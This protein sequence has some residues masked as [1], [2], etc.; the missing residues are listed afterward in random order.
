MS[1]QSFTLQ[2]S[3]SPQAPLSTFPSVGWSIVLLLLG[4]AV[5]W[6]LARRRATQDPVAKN[7]TG[8]LDGEQPNFTQVLQWVGHAK[9]FEK[10][11][12]YDE[13]VSIYD[14]GLTQHPQ[15]FRL[16]HERGL[17]LARLGRFEEAISSYDRAYELKPTQRDLAHERGDALLKLERYEEAIASFN[18]YL[19]Y[20]PNSGH[21]LSDKG[22]VLYQLNRYEEAL[23]ALNK[24]LNA[25]DGDR[26]AKAYAHSYQIAALQKLGQLEAA[27]KSCQTAL[28]R[29]PQ[30]SFKQQYEMLQQ[31]IA[32]AS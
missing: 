17:A 15:D 27:L 21:V 19:N 32:E 22:Y 24:A 11:N 29:Y 1:R 14:R 28:Q 5:G 20:V 26:N 18:V 10:L 8:H 23:Q 9:A 25:N 3:E 12:Q 7:K 30:D 2:P 16:W 6:Q 4:G 31:Q 13:A